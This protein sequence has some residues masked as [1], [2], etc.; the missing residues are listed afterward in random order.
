VNKLLDNLIALL[1][2][3]LFCGCVAGI[4]A[5]LFCALLVDWQYGA[6]G[7]FRWAV[8][9]FLAGALIFS[10]NLW[11]AKRVMRNVKRLFNGS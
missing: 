2:R 6:T 1:L 7:K 8:A 4:T 11:R 9:G 5:C 10:L 3:A